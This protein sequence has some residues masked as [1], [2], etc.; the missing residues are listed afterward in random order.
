MDRVGTVAMNILFDYVIQNFRLFYQLGETAIDYG[1]SGSAGI[2]IVQG[3]KVS[4]FKEKTNIHAEEVVW[5][6]WKGTKIP[7]LFDRSDHP[8][9]ISRE[10][11][12]VRINYD[13]IAACFYFLSG[14]DEHVNTEKDPLGRVL[15]VHSMINKLGISGLPVVNYYFDI[16]QE[17]ISSVANYPEKKVWTPHD[18]AVM[19]THDIDSCQ[20]AWLEGSLHELRNGRLHSV[21]IL[22][23]RKI[24][25]KDAWFNFSEIEQIEA[26]RNAHSSFYFL[27]RRGKSNGWNNADYAITDAKIQKQIALLKSSGNEIGVHGSFGTH[28]DIEKLAADIR[29]LG[30]DQVKGNRF[31]FLMFDPDASVGVLEKNDILYDS[32]LGFAEQPGFRRGT[33]FPFYLYNFEANRISPVI[34]FP[35][36]VMDTSLQHTKYLGVSPE[37]SLTI[38]KNLIGEI[39]KFGGVFTLLWH[40]THFSRYKYGGWKKVYEHTLDHCLENNAWMNSGIEIYHRIN[41][42]RGT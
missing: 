14:W 33:C 25:G 27:P 4:V 38:I 11:D 30:V 37:K 9:I 26:L 3:S 8:D 5:K 39:K 17:A 32:S 15:Y 36:T 12:K 21:P 13:I 1:T 28:D 34:E 24:F 10:G 23:L 7:F 35:L 41:T 22:L 18:F 40:N 29:N 20:S 19:L 42:H 6:T 31:H 16:L 2:H